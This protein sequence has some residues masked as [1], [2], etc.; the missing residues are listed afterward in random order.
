MPMQKIEP[1]ETLFSFN[2]TALGRSDFL[3][4]FRSQNDDDRAAPIGNGVAKKCAQMRFWI[5][6][7]ISDYPDDKEPDRDHAQR[8]AI[9]K[10]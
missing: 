8:M 3:Q 5:E 6:H 4:K 9:K 10:G 2:R 1:R 7:S